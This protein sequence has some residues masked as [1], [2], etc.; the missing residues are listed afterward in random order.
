MLG[1]YLGQFLDEN[2]AKRLKPFDDVA[3]VDDL[4]A[5]I[6]RRAIFLERQDNDLDG[7][8]D[9]G[10]ETSRLAKPQRQRRFWR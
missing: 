9:A 7:A 10:T 2:R 1:R 3:V 4:V 6:D 8:I 5:D